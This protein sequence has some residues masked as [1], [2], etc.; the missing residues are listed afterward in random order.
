MLTRETIKKNTG[1][2]DSLYSRFKSSPEYIAMEESDKYYHMDNTTIMGRKNMVTLSE[3]RTEED[4]NGVNT[5]YTYTTTKEDTTKAN[6][7]IPHGFHYELVNQCKNFLAGNPVRLSWKNVT[8]AD[9]FKVE[10][11]RILNDWNDWGTFNQIM[12]KDAQKYGKS[13]ARVSIHPRTGQLRFLPISPKELVVLKDEFE[14]IYLALR[15]YE[16]DSYNDEGEV[17]KVKYCEVLDDEK[18]D[19]Y[20]QQKGKWIHDEEVSMF[21]VQT[22]HGD[23]VTR[24]ES[25]SWGKVPIIEWKFTDDGINALAPI[26]D[27]IDLADSNLSDFAN[28]LDDINEL[29]WILKNYNGQDLNEFLR[30]V[31]ETKAIKV[32][33]DG[34][35]RTER[36]EL[37]Y[38]ARVELYDIVIRNIYRFGRGIDFTDRSNLGNITG[39]GLKWSYEL[40]EEKANELELH[41]QKAL[42][43]L[44]EFVFIYMRQEGTL[45]DDYDATSI[46]FIFDRS[47][48]INEQENVDTMLK[49]N[50]MGSLKTALENTSIVHDVDEELSRIEEEGDDFDVNAVMEALDGRVE[51]TED[52]DDFEESDVEVS[53]GSKDSGGKP[54]KE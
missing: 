40:L 32:G 25:K 49:F 28:D 17:V 11:D 36:N 37:P 31:K 15:Y 22:S 39:T 9:E 42:D 46:E 7:K 38:K 30:D 19:V 13:Y 20:T 45:K 35:V 10:L 52:P 16:I 48:M 5:V 18:K 27:F 43:D 51:R 14:D 54:T 33:A 50:Q 47:L 4:E 24:S 6:N 34:D 3:D 12:I 8:P 21:E 1:I 23:V 44:M 41:G 2:I 53:Q 26:K 29:V